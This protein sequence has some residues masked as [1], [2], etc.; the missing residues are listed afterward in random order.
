MPNK[1]SKKQV[2][3]PELPSIPKE[4]IEPFVSGSM[5]AEAVNAVSIAFKKAPIERALGAEL[6]HPLGY[7]AG[8]DQPATV[9]A[10]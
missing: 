9:A 2:A 1:T 7:P 5:T 6:T 3:A 8:G 10:S 4:L